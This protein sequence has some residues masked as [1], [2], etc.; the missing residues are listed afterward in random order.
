MAR[1][2]LALMTGIM[3]A[4]HFP[5][6]LAF[7]LGCLSIPAAMLLSLSIRERDELT[8]PLAWAA[9]A[10]AV[11]IG[12]AARMESQLREWTAREAAVER[13]AEGPP[14]TI[15][16]FVEDIRERADG[17]SAVTLADVSL[18]RDG[19]V[20]AL[21]SKIEVY[22]PPELPVEADIGSI[23]TVRAGISPIAGPALPAGFDFRGHQR[24]RGVFAAAYLDAL[25][26]I[27]I[28][29][30][31][32]TAGSAWARSMARR[33][34][35]L[36]DGWLSETGWE[37]GAA[38]RLVPPVALGIR[39]GAPDAL[40]RALSRSG[41]AHI[42]SISGLHVSL[43][44]GLIFFG[45]K[46][47]GLRRKT[48]AWLTA[49]AAVLYVLMVGAR[50][51][52]LRSALMAFV[53]L[54]TFF[55]QRP[56]DPVNSLGLAA[57]LL[58]M[59]D[60][61]ELFLPSFQLSFAAVLA[62][63]LG[64]PSQEWIRAKTPWRPVSWFA[65]GTAAS[66]LVCAAVMPLTMHYFHLATWGAAIGNLFAVPAVAVF[67]PLTY[68]WLAAEAL[69]VP[70][71]PDALGHAVAWTAEGIAAVARL[72]SEP[73]WMWATVA[74]PGLHWKAMPLLALLFLA[75]PRTVLAEG[76]WFRLRG[77]QAA[78]TAVIAALVIEFAG[79]ALRP[80]RIDFLALGQGD[81]V[82]IRTPGG[83]TAL[84]DGG[85]PAWNPNE[86]TFVPL[87][88]VLLGLGVDHLDAVIVTHPQADHIGEIPRALETATAGLLIEGSEC[89]GIEACGELREALERRGVP[90]TRVDAGDRIELEPG[91]VLW[92]LH[93]PEGA[94]AEAGGDINERSLVLLLEYEGFRALLTGDIGLETEAELCGRYGDWDVDVIK[95]PH[96][97]SRFSSGEALIRET[98]PE[99]AAIQ[100]GRNPYGH[101]HPDAVGRYEDH[102][103]IVLRGDVDGT[104]RVAVRGPAGY[105][106]SATRSGRLF[107]L[108]RTP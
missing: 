49:A 14:H 56:I 21:D 98:R 43:M 31:E 4:R 104:V 82:L 91:V 62:L 19:A 42:T 81:C 16:G 52:A 44:I 13:L 27:R 45:A 83:R 26:E 2:A 108:E 93:P 105:R 33:L 106:V 41:L 34:A 24:A 35:A 8:R 29:N 17:G 63:A 72:F 40:Q 68:A 86:Y 30:P 3:Y 97:G 76:G 78:M 38:A 36:A 61:S 77:Y 101:P 95:V 75:R 96:H 100:T 67:L 32:W 48:A 71:L 50:I 5:V 80:L 74:D 102:G 11:C 99:F 15:R 47:A 37:G 70:V 6:N 107:V 79:G 66:L 60:P 1:T 64:A 20:R 51:P 69:S 65:R 12:G 92:A 57:A 25:H 9:V 59:I 84:V 39:G 53:F 10:L 22:A 18:E 87:Q 55:V 46:R 73:G 54:G 103:A 58:L 23:V 7:A 88:T 85:P 28:E 94:E 89:A 90:R